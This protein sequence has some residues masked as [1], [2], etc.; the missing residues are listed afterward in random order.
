MTN[1]IDTLIIG[2]GIAGSCLAWALH[3]HGQRIVLVDRQE[4]MTASRVAAGLIAPLSG[5]RLLPSWHFDTAWATAKQFYKSLLEPVFVERGKLHFF[6]SAEERTLFQTCRVHEFARYVADPEVTV[7]STMYDAPYGAF[8]MSHSAWVDIPRFLRLTWQQFPHQTATITAAD[9]TWQGRTVIVKKLDLAAARVIWCEGPLQSTNPLFPGLKFKLA[10][11][12][13]LT[14]RIPGFAEER[15]LH[16]GVWLY[17]VADD[18]YRC[19]SNY[20]WTDLSP[21]PTPTA[22]EW[23]LAQLR[24]FLKCPVDVLDQQTA[25]RPVLEDL[26]PIL[27]VHP[28]CQ[29]LV[30]FNGL[31]S[32]GALLAPYLAEQFAADRPLPPEVRIERSCGIQ[33]RPRQT[34]LAHQYI[35]RAIRVGD[36]VIDATAGNG[37]DTAFLA[38]RVGRHGRVYAIDIQPEAIQTITDLHRPN[39]QAILADHATL[40][41]I[42]PPDMHGKIAAIMFNLGYRPHGNHAIVTH[43]ESTITAIQGAIRLLRPGGVMTILAYTGHP[44]GSE[45][46][47]AVVGVLRQQHQI[48]WHEEQAEPWRT[49]VPRLFVVCRRE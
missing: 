8:E 42:I 45:E 44:G 28:G 12:E 35:S 41:T 2:A 17:R 26:K 9:L 7:D 47:E 37:H 4:P 22:R 20:E 6:S 43:V 34:E 39:V 25:I 14:L 31:G 48:D 30:I 21:E 40:P 24:T 23:I 11:G 49:N 5:P 29:Q 16:R 46:A 19:G 13:V 3:R 38:T 15:V 1:H 10:K 36:A 18:V 33:L 32:K 27:G